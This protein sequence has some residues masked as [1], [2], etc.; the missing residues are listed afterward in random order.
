M[1]LVLT[2]NV[3]TLVTIQQS[4][5]LM[6]IAIVK[7]IKHHVNVHQVL[8][9]IPHQIKVVLEFH[10]F[11]QEPKNVLKVTCV[12]L[13][14]VTYHV[15]ILAHVQLVNVALITCVQRSVIL[16]TIV[17]LVKFVTKAFVFLAV[18]LMLIVLILKFVF[19]LN[20]NAEKDLMEHL[21]DVMILMNVVNNFAT[22]Q[23]LVKIFLGHTNVLAHQVQ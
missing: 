13:T 4:V 3:K 21:S 12:L 14:N 16:T 23:L 10:Q 2:I 9:P 19:N 11:A 18:H 20:V 8:K 15:P 17:C 6:L 1:K 7:I 5:D 22:H